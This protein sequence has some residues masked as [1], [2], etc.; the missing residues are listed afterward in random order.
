MMRNQHISQEKIS[1][2]KWSMMI[3][4]GPVLMLTFGL[5]FSISACPA[6]HIE[7]PPSKS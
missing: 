7:F 2:T 4:A 6:L 1:I 3:H 5:R